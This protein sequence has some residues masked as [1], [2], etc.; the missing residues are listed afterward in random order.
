MFLFKGVLSGFEI[1]FQ[2]AKPCCKDMCPLD[3]DLP[4]QGHENPKTL[5]SYLVAGGFLKA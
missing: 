2:G 4:N 1:I 3:H 5:P